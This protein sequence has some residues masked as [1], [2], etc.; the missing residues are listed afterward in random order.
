M[1]CQAVAII[2]AIA[3]CGN[4]F[5]TVFTCI[6]QARLPDV[7]GAEKLVPVDV[8]VKLGALP[9]RVSTLVPLAE[10]LGLLSSVVGFRKQELAFITSSVQLLFSLSTKLPQAITL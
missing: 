4:A 10:T 3:A 7:C 9:S 1:L 2:S 8:W 5:G 6:A